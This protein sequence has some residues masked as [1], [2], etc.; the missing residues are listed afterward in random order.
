MTYFLVR[1]AKSVNCVS[2]TAR[3]FEMLSV[4]GQRGL[5]SGDMRLDLLNEV[6]S[7]P[8][9]FASPEVDNLLFEARASIAAQMSACVNMGIVSH[10]KS[11][12]DRGWSPHIPKIYKFIIKSVIYHNLTLQL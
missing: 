12:R 5:P 3:I 2:V 10:V 9:F 6:G 1:R 7:K 8:A 11:I 4:E